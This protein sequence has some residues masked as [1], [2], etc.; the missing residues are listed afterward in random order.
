MLN[1]CSYTRP[2]P[3][4]KEQIHRFKHARRDWSVLV[5]ACQ[6]DIVLSCL[7]ST[8]ITNTEHDKLNAVYYGDTRF[9]YRRNLCY[10]QNGYCYLSLRLMSMISI[11]FDYM[12]HYCIDCLVSFENI[13]LASG[14]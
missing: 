13:C 1:I 7:N 3:R 14:L 5:L 6:H 4:Y 11:H 10:R 2:N 9:R 12:E 8:D